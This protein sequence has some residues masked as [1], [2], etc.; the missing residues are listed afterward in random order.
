ME[1]NFKHHSQEEALEILK[2]IISSPADY[3]NDKVLGTIAQQLMPKAPDE[4]GNEIFL[5]QTG[6]QFSVFGNKTFEIIL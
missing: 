1:K 6:I 3:V 2:N 4:I 5:N